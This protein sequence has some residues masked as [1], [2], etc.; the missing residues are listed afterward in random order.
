[1]SEVEEVFV[2]CVVL[3]LSNTSDTALVQ[4]CTHVTSDFFDGSGPLSSASEESHE[5]RRYFVDVDSIVTEATLQIQTS[6]PSRTLGPDVS[7]L[8]HART[9]TPMADSI[10]I[11]VCR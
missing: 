9:L 4:R 11:F 2:K 7:H 1:M 3:V 10:L 8:F 6:F 5:R